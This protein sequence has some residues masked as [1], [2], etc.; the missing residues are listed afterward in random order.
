MRG[1]VPEAGKQPGRP[2]EG[3]DRLLALGAL[4]QQQPPVEGAGKHRR[5]VPQLPPG[6]TV[7]LLDRAAVPGKTL[8]TIA[9]R[10]GEHPARKAR[11]AVGLAAA[12][13]LVVEVQRWVTIA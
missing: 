7:G 4:V 10:L 6:A 12:G 8:R 9:S 2:S 11:D 1:R 13:R 3:V 5:Q